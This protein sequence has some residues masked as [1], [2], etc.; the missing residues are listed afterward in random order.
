METINI[1]V[2][3]A[4]KAVTEK[5]AT[6]SNENPATKIPNFVASGGATKRGR[7]L[8]GQAPRANAIL[9]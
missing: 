6:R 7:P 4:L 1:L 5:A 3:A 2:D 8:K 9:L